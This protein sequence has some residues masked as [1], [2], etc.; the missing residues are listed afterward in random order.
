M[1]SKQYNQ[2]VKK[3]RLDRYKFAFD[4][5]N[6]T[7]HRNPE[8][9]E[10]GAGYFHTK[11]SKKDK[12]LA[13]RIT[14]PVQLPPK[15]D[16]GY[17]DPDLSADLQVLTDEFLDQC[18]HEWAQWLA[19][20]YRRNELLCLRYHLPSTPIELPLAETSIALRHKEATTDD[21]GNSI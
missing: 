6:L 18:I 2:R 21:Y 19:E 15:S 20:Q 13:S 5:L 9:S 12:V 17:G 3:E 4:H 8:P 7:K 1:T 11:K 16:L 14:T 10:A